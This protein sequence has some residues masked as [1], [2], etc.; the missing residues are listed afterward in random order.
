MRAVVVTSPG[1]PGA[2]RVEDVP[3]PTPGPGQVLVDVAAAGV[4]RADLLQRAGHYPPPPGAPAWPGLEASGVVLAVG[5]SAAAQGGG[6]PAL[7][8]TP[9]LRVGD[10]VAALLTGGGYAERVIAEAS[11]TLP[12]PPE[13]DIQD[14]AALPE[15][16]ATVWSNLRAAALGPGQTLLVH[17]GSGGVG[18]VAV[19]LAHAL[20]HRV[21][22][23]AGGAE[24]CARVRELGA[25]VVVDHR[26]QDVTAA[27]LDATEGRGVD[28]VLDV[29]GGRALGANVRLLAEGGRLVVIGLQQGRRGE[30]DLPA[31][32][33]RRGSVIATTLRDRPAEQKAAIMADVRAH[34]WP[35]VLDG[36]VR[37]VVHARVP[38]AQAPRAHEMLESGEVF[39]KVLLLP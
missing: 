39:G 20:G 3:D 7:Q 21:L 23:T 26:A 24:R 29:L 34:V 38:L 2:L 16:L 28:V 13:G 32:M 36:R 19:Q 33:A 6:D 18:S 10:R 1:G 35:L 15:A 4:N 27:V 37:P 25:D 17:G 31:L 9:V 12:I 14:A 5:P 30:L 22:A 11:L 8:G